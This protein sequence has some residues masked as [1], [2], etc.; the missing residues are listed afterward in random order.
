MVDGNLS[1][2]FTGTISTARQRC[3]HMN[4]HIWTPRGDL[5]DRLFTDSEIRWT[6]SVRY[7]RT[8]LMREDGVIFEPEPNYLLDTPS[9]V[10]AKLAN[11][12]LTMTNHLRLHGEI[13]DRCLC[14]NHTKAS[15]FL[16]MAFILILLVTVMSSVALF[17]LTCK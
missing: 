5:S 7:N 11:N 15:F 2:Q 14:V 8:H 9:E 17:F 16:T 3:N 4:G 12:K 6:G 13:V 1:A 10:V